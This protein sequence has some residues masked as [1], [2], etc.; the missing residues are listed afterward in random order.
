VTLFGHSN[1][2]LAQETSPLARL[3]PKRVLL[4]FGEVMS[5]PG[6][7]MFEQAVR[8]EL[9]KSVTNRI[10]FFTEDLDSARF[11]DEEQFRVFRNYLNRRYARKR[12]PDLIIAFTGRNFNLATDLRRSI[13]PTEPFLFVAGTEAEIPSDLAEL[14]LTGIVQRLDVLGTLKL[15]LRL[16]PETHRVVVIGGVS[17]TDRM[18]LRRIED[19]ARTFD[20]L[21]FD[22]WTNRPIAELPAAAAA[23]PEN[24]AILLS[25]VRQDVT[26]QAF[27]MIQAEQMLA[28]VSRAPIYT[29][30]GGLIGGGA[31]G[32][33]VIDTEVL[34]TRIAQMG[35]P[36]LDGLPI[37][38]QPVEI[39]TNGTP[40]VDWRAL[41]RWQISESRLPANCVVHYQPASL[42]EEHR[43]L[44][45]T[46]LAVFLAQ[47]VTIAALLTQRARRRWAEA[48]IQRQRA[49]L[50]H[51]TR[52]STA[53][54]LASALAHEL[55][56]PLGAILRNAEAAEIFLQQPNPDLAE[57]RAILA[58]I[59]KDDQ[60][61]G[62]V[63]DRLRSLLKRRNLEHDT[64]NLSE[65]L[66][67]TVKL[68]EPEAAARRIKVALDLPPRAPSVKG[69]RVQLQQVALNLILNGMDATETGESPGRQ[70]TVRLREAAEGAEVAVLDRGIGIPPDKLPRLFEPFFTT[71]P[72]G[73]GMGLAISRTI[74]ET[75]GGKLRGENNPDGGATFRF[76][77]PVNGT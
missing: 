75:H 21:G 56:Q 42:W 61:A 2:S 20:R 45:L 39:R 70:V 9:Q 3:R 31:L 67:E 25:S 69:D 77:L 18:F 32:G 7:V 66:Q 62:G 40:M 60:R 50:A 35:R 46:A 53:G 34:G 22:F 52:V 74:I 49:E 43:E 23:L 57:L 38:N 16:Q 14:G 11:P 51:A 6:N 63:I 36:A 55:N 17:D 33:S 30:G 13:F 19:A 41:K 72:N 4:L 10:E 76:T 58:D 28:P 44:I 8:A 37:T 29:F 24:S 59:R 26:G 54:Q 73:M 5:L 12:K 15:M 68:V 65:L 27:Y 71:K 47:G 64:I 48:E 1:N